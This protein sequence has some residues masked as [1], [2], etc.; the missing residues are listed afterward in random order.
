MKLG[1]DILPNAGLIIITANFANAVLCHP[2][3]SFQ[4]EELTYFQQAYF[5]QDSDQVLLTFTE[6]QQFF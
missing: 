5:Q 6:R 3:I 4:T 1:V 2:N